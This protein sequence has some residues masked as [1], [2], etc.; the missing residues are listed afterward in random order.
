LPRTCDAYTSLWDYDF[1]IKF[2]SDSQDNYLRVPLASFAANYETDNGA[3]AIFVEY[4]NAASSNSRQIIFGG[5]FF[6]SIYAQFEQEETYTQAQLW[7]NKNA[8][9]NTYIG[10]EVLP[11]GNSPFVVKMRTIPTDPSSQKNGLPTF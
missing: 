3:C 11:Q 5:M 2:S 10:N 7:V 1:K 9:K 4:L 8:L 6:Q